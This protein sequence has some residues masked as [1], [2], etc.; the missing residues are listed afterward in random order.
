M[1]AQRMPALALVVILGARPLDNSASTMAIDGH[2]EKRSQCQ[3]TQHHG[4]Q[5]QAISRN[6]RR[7]LPEIRVLT[8]IAVIRIMIMIRIIAVRIVIVH[9]KAFLWCN[10]FV[11]ACSY[12]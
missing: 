11:N 8:V 9:E 12:A 7:I 6:M 2:G 3:N 1:A 10:R 5:C 4:R